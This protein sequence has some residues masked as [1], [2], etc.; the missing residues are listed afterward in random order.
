MYHTDNLG[1]LHACSASACMT[2]LDKT[3]G[4]SVANICDKLTHLEL[5]TQLHPMQPRM[6]MATCSD[7][8]VTKQQETAAE[9][10]MA[11]AWH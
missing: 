9:L 7:H 5:A 11:C 1:S 4:H 2:G 8:V 6:L 3:M 10:L